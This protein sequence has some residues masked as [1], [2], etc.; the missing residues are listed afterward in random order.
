MSSDDI[1]KIISKFEVYEAFIKRKDS[2]D[3]EI[4]QDAAESAGR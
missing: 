2:P 4:K 1:I 3:E